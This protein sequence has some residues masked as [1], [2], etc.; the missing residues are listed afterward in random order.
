MLI[1]LN[2]DIAEILQF[3]DR[4]IVEMNMISFWIQTL[5]KWYE[6]PSKQKDVPNEP[7]LSCSLTNTKYHTSI[8]ILFNNHHHISILISPNNQYHMASMILTSN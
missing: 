5:F 3:L 1:C 8:I 7:S 4:D 6:E 2:L